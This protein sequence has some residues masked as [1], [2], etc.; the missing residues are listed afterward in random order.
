MAGGNCIIGI[1][2]IRLQFGKC[3]SGNNIGIFTIKFGNTL[4]ENAV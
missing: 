4:Y 2:A 3:S 1:F